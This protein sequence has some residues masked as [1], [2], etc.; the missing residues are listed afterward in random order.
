VS[1]AQ[2]H[3]QGGSTITQQLAKINYTAGERTIFRKLREVLYASR[4]EQR[5]TKDQL[6]ERYLNQV[7]FGDGAYGIEA[8]A[9]TFFGVHA[10]Q[11]SPAQAALLAGKIRAPEIL[12]PRKRPEAVIGRRDQVLDALAARGWLPRAEAAAAKA[13]AGAARAEAQRVL[14][15]AH[16]EADQIIERAH[17]QAEQDAEQARL[18]ARRSGEREVALLTAAAKEQ[19]EEIERRL[20]TGDFFEFLT[21]V[22]DEW[23]GDDADEL[24]ELL[25][26]QLAEAGI[27]VKTE[28]RG[29]EGETEDEDEDEGDVDVEPDEEEEDA[30]TDL[31]EDPDDALLDDE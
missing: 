28:G 22:L 20:D 13:E 24:I 7:Y 14:A 6:L 18:T 3:T 27:D 11:L 12:D 15:A 8:A 29:E 19:V 25:E 16:T 17:R 9:R 2:G 1:T 5:Y 23:S 21:D 26:T 4:L 31:D 30:A 10:A